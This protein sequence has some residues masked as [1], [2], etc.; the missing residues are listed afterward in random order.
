MILSKSICK[1]Y[2][3]N[4]NDELYTPEILVKCLEKSFDNWAYDFISFYQRAPTVWMP[5]DKQDSEFVLYFKDKTFANYYEGW[6]V[7]EYKVNIEFSHI[8]YDQDFFKYEPKRWDIAISNP[9]F[10]RK[11]DVF[12]RLNSFKKPFTMVMNTM[13]LNYHE[14]CSYFADNPVELL[15]P[16]K[17]ISFDGNPSSFN[18]C[19][20]CK[21]FLNSKLEFIHVEHNNTGSNFKPSRMYNAQNNI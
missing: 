3:P 10:S 16:D 21:N 4:K 7:A 9:P 19:F 20:V 1:A 12:K 2:K 11:L 15:I 5:F 6:K 8:D 18:S 13:A 17:R 14:I